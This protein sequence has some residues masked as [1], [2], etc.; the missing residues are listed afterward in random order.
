MPGAMVIAVWRQIR[1]GSAGGWNTLARP[2][3]G[4]SEAWRSGQI[5]RGCLPAAG[6][7]RRW[8]P[9]ASGPSLR[10]S[11]QPVRPRL[12]LIEKQWPS[13][14]YCAQR[15]PP[16]VAWT[17]SLLWEIDLYGRTFSADA[18]ADHSYLVVLCWAD[19]GHSLLA[20]IQE[21]RLLASAQH[22][23]P[24]SAR[25]PGC[26]LLRRIFRLEAR[27]RRLAYLTCSCGAA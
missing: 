22:S 15:E 25:E 1:G 20:D 9:S 16:G 14:L 13:S 5:S 18:S 7:D 27:R 6:Q 11:W 21:G 26:A 17:R 19:C 23:C 2:S 12:R 4:D 8:Y 3:R 24:F 10:W